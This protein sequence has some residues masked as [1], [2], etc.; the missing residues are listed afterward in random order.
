MKHE[1][2]AEPEI[3]AFARKAIDGNDNHGSVVEP[4][5]FVWIGGAELTQMKPRKK[6]MV[7]EQIL[8]AGGLTVIASK[9]K[10][11]KTT[12]MVEFCHAVST[13]RPALGKYSVMHGPV[14]YW[15]ADDA[16]VDRFAENWRIVSG[17]VSVENFH[18]CVRRQHL[19]PDGIVNLRKATEK[20]RP[21][22]IVVDAYTTI[23]TP[24]KQ[25]L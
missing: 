9:S 11:G 3:D 4:E 15:L 2:V 23:R 21:V 7:V 25:G 14:L 1:I 8:P 6:Q 17:D 10:S 20:F 24:R 13:G 19:F 18:L 5:P 16:N 12:L 22:L